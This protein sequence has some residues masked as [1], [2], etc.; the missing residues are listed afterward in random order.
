MIGVFYFFAAILLYLSVRSFIGGIRYL[1]FFQ[2][3]L[4]KPLSE[5]TPFVTVIAPCRGVDHGFSENIS[6]LLTQAYPDFEVLFV[7]DDHDDPAVPVIEKATAAT[8]VHTRLVIAKRALDSGQKVENL[9]EGVMHA[10]GGSEVFAFVDSD[11]RL[12]PDWL[13]R[14]VAPLNVPSVG[15]TTGYR[16]FIAK[17]PTLATELR[18]VWNASIASALGSNTSSNF[19][20]G[21]STAIRRDVFERVEMREKWR[22]TVSDDFAVT[23][24]LNKAGMPIVFVPGAMPVTEDDRGFA[25]LLEFTT[26]QMQITRVYASKLW[27]MSFIGSALFMGVMIAAVAIIILSERNDTGV[28]VSLLILLLVTIL[29]TG[30][31][32]LRLAAVRLVL[33][34]YKDGLARQFWPQITLWAITPALF[35]YNSVGAWLSRRMRWRGT[36]YELKSP[37]ETVIIKD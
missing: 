37:N 33:K 14:L 31:A 9:R 18:S 28:I 29:G 16:W 22:G 13:R 21:G 3:E 12:S 7:V 17:K 19:C 1:A 26:R 32:W 6:S 35:F 34:E 23:R 25:N 36:V 2:S 11:V 20:W 8:T 5:F 4:A 15:A 24:T 30:K 27:L 10:A